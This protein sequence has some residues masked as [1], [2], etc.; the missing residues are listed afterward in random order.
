MATRSRLAPQDGRERCLYIDTDG[1]GTAPSANL[2]HGVSKHVVL[3]PQQPSDSEQHA[4]VRDMAQEHISYSNRRMQARSRVHGCGAHLK[5]TQ[6]SPRSPVRARLRPACFVWTQTASP[7]AKRKE[8][9]CSTAAVRS[10][11]KAKGQRV[12]VDC[13]EV[14]SAK[15]AREKR[16]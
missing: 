4:P 11:R 1:S 3:T 6:A 16:S 12:A 8:P 5:P 14:R 7:E 15:E 2:A 10:A 9:P 13:G